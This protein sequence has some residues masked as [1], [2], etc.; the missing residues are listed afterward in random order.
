MKKVIMSTHD[1]I[2][3]AQVVNTVQANRKRVGVSYKVGDLVYL[4][5]KNILLPKGW[6]Q[7][8][9]PKHPGLLPIARILRDSATYQL[10]LSNKLLKQGI[11]HSF[12]MSLLKPH[13][14][15]ND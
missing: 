13:V 14:P 8:L 3:A 7:K 1:S 9:A 5:T 11:N 12:H 6:A 2:I 15:S 4:S 10:D